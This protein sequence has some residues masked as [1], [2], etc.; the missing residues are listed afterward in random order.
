MVIRLMDR[1]VTNV[2]AVRKLRRDSGPGRILLFLGELGEEERSRFETRLNG[3]S[4]ECGCAMAKFAA[5]AAAILYLV[6]LVE[7]GARLLGSFWTVGDVGIVFVGLVA[8]AGRIIGIKQADREF[9]ETTTELAGILSGDVP[10]KSDVFAVVAAGRM[11]KVKGF[12]LQE[13]RV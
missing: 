6:F 12:G 11:V 7:G 2:E 10:K 3:L 4:G 8:V 9:Q 5:V 1:V 13:R